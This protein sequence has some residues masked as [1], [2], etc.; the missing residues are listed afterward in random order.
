MP[1]ETSEQEAGPQAVHKVTFTE[2]D[3]VHLMLG[4]LE[5]RGLAKSILA[6]E[7]ETGVSNGDWLPGSTMAFV[8]DTVL[9]GRW[10]EL[11]LLLQPLRKKSEKEKYFKKI[12]I[13]VEKQ[14]LL[15]LLYAMT[16]PASPASSAGLPAGSDESEMERF[17][18][19]EAELVA[20]TML[21]LKQLCVTDEYN[22][23]C[24]LVMAD[25]FRDCAGYSHWTPASSRL[26]IFKKVR[27]L[28]EEALG[29]TVG[30]EAKPGDGEGEAEAN[31]AP[32]PQDKLLQL[33]LCGAV[34]EQ[35]CSGFQERCEKGS[36]LASVMKREEAGQVHGDK[37]ESAHCYTLQC[38]ISSWLATVPKRYFQEPYA[39]K[40]T[41]K[42]RY[43]LQKLPLPPKKKGF[44]IRRRSCPKAIQ[45]AEPNEDVDAAQSQ[46]RLSRSDGFKPVKQTQSRSPLEELRSIQ[47]AEHKAEKVRSHDQETQT[48]S[49]P[50]LENLPSIRK[51][52]QKAEEVQQKDQN[53]KIRPVKERAPA[54]RDDPYARLPARVAQADYV[55][56]DKPGD[57]TVKGVPPPRENPHLR[58]DPELSKSECLEIV[59]Q[60]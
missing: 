27:C 32:S 16:S 5:E 42:T 43:A 44:R 49:Q 1:V 18:R 28:Y 51:V 6:L 3:I 38:S 4:Y 29:Y 40:A 54:V 50:P 13:L 47:R 56:M 39:S 53:R 46:D 2:A 55:L 25:N 20:R 17:A 26:E 11:L 23:L 22:A 59:F 9:H 60:S 7:D 33:L 31:P 15:E 41:Q 30:S 8:R 48:Q 19:K 21:R 12:Q 52:E 57:M 37:E 45:P 35:L 58:D 14:R 36:P 10:D 24:M 34:Y